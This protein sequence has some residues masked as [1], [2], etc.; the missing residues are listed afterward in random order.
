MKHTSRSK[1]VACLA[2]VGMAVGCQSGPRNFENENDRLRSENLQLQRRVADL[3]AQAQ[4]KAALVH[5]LE[6]RIDAKPRVEGVAAGALP[7][8]VAVK[9]SRFSGAVDTNGDGVDDVIR[10]YTQT[11]DQRGRFLPAV[12]P[13]VAQVVAINADA[14][15]RPVATRRFTPD[16][17]E[18]AY[19]TGITGTHYTLEVPLDAQATQSLEQVTV[20]LIFTDAATGAEHT[21][22]QAIAISSGR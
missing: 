4:Q 14:P 16:E 8:V 13:A 5:T 22:E 10:L 18:Q 2:V 20:K 15:P 9:F 3:Q 17:F 19:R 21:R 7:Q 12:G 1:V 11:L 6:Q